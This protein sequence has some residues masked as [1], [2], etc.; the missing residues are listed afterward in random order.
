M[1]ATRLELVVEELKLEDPDLENA[2]GTLGI[3]VAL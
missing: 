2:A 1:Y 3:S